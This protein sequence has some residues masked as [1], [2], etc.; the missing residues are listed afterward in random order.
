MNARTE[1]LACQVLSL[2]KV[3]S[4]ESLGK[5]TV[6]PSID[7]A[8]KGVTDVSIVNLQMFLVVIVPACSDVLST[9]SAPSLLNFRP[10]E[11]DASNEP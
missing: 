11:M 5:G 4:P 7:V 9:V 2:I 6:A 3:T 8:W 1:T 10:S